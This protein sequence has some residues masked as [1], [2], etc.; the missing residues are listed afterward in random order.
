[1]DILKTAIDWA[2]SEI[3]SSMFFTTSGLIFIGTT[4]GFWQLGKTEIAKAYIYPTL[5]AGIFLIS[6]GLGIFFLNNSRPNSFSTGFNQDSRGFVQSEISRTEKLIS[7]YETAVFKVIPVI[8][9]IATLLTIF[10]DKPIWRAISITTIA[11]MGI[12]MIIDS[13]AHARVK[14]YNKQLVLSEKLN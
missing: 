7:E 12:I 4:V 6:V 14:E 10:I 3:F 13:N 2:K 5:V 8:I 1:M 9:T 11:M